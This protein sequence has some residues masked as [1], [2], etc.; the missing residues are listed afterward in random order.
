M[1]E[2]GGRLYF[3]DR[4]FVL[5]VCRGQ[6]RPDQ[7]D[8]TVETVIF[9][10]GDAADLLWCLATYRN[11]ENYPLTNLNHFKSKIDA[12]RYLSLVEPTVPLI[13]LGGQSPNDP[14]SYP[15]VLEWKE[16]NNY[17]DYDYRRAYLPGGSN[18]R[19]VIVQTTDQFLEAKRK[20]ARTLEP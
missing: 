3:D 13:S 19:E 11:C 2:F 12:M 15:N 4:L 18:P 16:R 6:I 10:E 9:H 8:G 14:L 17:F 5:N 20:V 7:S 1:I